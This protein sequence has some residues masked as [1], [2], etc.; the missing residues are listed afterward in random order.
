[1]S[2]PYT[3]FVAGIANAFPDNVSDP[4]YSRWCDTYNRQIRYNV[5]QK[6]L[7]NVALDDTDTRTIVIPT[8]AVLGDWQLIMLR[9]S[10]SVAGSA[11]KLLLTVVGKDTDGTTTITGY[12][13][14]YGTSYFPGVVFLSG[15]NL[16]SLTM[17]GQADGTTI[18]VFHAISEEDS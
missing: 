8:S 16:T 12:Q 17:T 6:L 2:A 18:D 11:G 10:S 3:L 9:V 13:R 5:R 1:M 7:E 14:A 15:Y 4:F